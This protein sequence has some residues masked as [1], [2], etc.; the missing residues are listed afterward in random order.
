MQIQLQ[1]NH[2]GLI[3][4]PGQRASLIFQMD[5]LCAAVAQQQIRHLTTCS[6]V[7]VKEI[8]TKVKR[9]GSYRAAGRQIISLAEVVL[10]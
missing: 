7:Q 5:V 1:L 2:S 8:I 10:L 6:Q 4:L 9:A 3:I